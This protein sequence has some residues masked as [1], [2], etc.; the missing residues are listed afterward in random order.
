M[1]MITCIKRK[2][3]KV[4]KKRSVSY[5]SIGNL[6]H[7]PPPLFLWS[8]ITETKASPLSPVL[9]VADHLQT[10]LLGSFFADPYPHVS[11]FLRISVSAFQVKHVYRK[12]TC[13]WSSLF[14]PICFLSIS[15]YDFFS[16]KISLADNKPPTKLAIVFLF[17]FSKTSNVEADT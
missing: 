13:S 4:Q 8:L 1:M 3:P 17:T 12:Q 15:A 6:R 11:I 9:V 10:L 16:P 2:L 14:K 7:S 5:L